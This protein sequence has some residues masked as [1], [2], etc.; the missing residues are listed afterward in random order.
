MVKAC[1]GYSS[2]GDLGNVPLHAAWN[3]PDPFSL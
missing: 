3:F 2:R 1:Q